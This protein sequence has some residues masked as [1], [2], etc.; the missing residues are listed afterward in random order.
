MIFIG[1]DAVCIQMEITI[2]R[3][4]KSTCTT[5]VIYIIPFASMVLILL[6]LAFSGMNIVTCT[7]SM[8]IS[9]LYTAY[10]MIW[11][12]FC[13]DKLRIM[14]SRVSNLIVFIVFIIV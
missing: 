5:G 7:Y 3:G 1:I 9:V 14:I 6:F 11:Y 2:G 4:G 10:M 8:I 13:N 12:F